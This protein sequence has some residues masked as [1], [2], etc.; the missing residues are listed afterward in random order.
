MDLRLVVM[1][2]LA[3]TPPPTRAQFVQILA[4]AID[5]NADRHLCGEITEE[6]WT[7]EQWRLWAIAAECGC[8]RDVM[9]L[10]A[11]SCVASGARS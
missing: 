6:R 8:A 1:L 3:A 9:A 5:I 2:T 4:N 7:I 10:I 11:P